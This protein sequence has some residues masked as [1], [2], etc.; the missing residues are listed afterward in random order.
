MEFVANTYSI[1]CIAVAL[2]TS[3][4]AGTAR[5]S[6][7]KIVGEVEYVETQVATQSL[8]M[9]YLFG[10]A[11]VS[12]AIFSLSAAQYTANPTDLNG[13]SYTSHEVA[14]YPE[15]SVSC[16]T[17]GGAGD[18]ITFTGVTTTALG[19]WFIWDIAG[20]KSSSSTACFDS[21]ATAGSGSS[22]GTGSSCL[23]TGCPGYIYS[24]GTQSGTNCIPS[25][26]G[27][28]CSGSSGGASAI[29]PSTSNGLVL[30]TMGDGTGPTESLP[31]PSGAYYDC[32]YFIGATDAE[33][34]CNGDGVGH[35]Y[36]SGTS[37]LDYVWYI[38]NS[39]GTSW[40]AA[41]IALVAAPSAAVTPPQVF[42]IRP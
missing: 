12:G 36:N 10:N 22:N 35:I 18:V 39:G 32:T 19:T 9:P 13:N 28:S 14:D 33:T 25:G 34:F 7:I 41:A 37:E 17:T 5:G 24:A 1:N 23:T 15:Y 30:S 42:V 3:V 2:K 26:T 40:G 16:G 38:N 29:I 21:S 6:G 31:S 20:A 27:S 11:I 4:G 8:Q